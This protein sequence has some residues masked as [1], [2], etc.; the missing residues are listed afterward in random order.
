MVGDNIG[1]LPVGVRINYG[2]GSTAYIEIQKFLHKSKSDIVTRESIKQHLLTISII[3]APD[4]T[5]INELEKSVDASNSK[6]SKFI[7]NIMEKAKTSMANMPMD[8]PMTAI[9]SFYNSGIVQD[10]VGGLK[11]G[12]GNG[13]MD[14]NK[15]FGSMQ[16]SMSGLMNEAS[17]EVANSTATVTTES[18][19][20]D[21]SSS[22]TNQSTETPKAVDVD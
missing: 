14:M 8:D 5:K 1:S 10:L 15:L 19:S 18:L 13:D 2:N 21:K 16:A 20:T 11:E 9:L 4:Q 7:S 12:V 22:G 3:L 6:E 17:Q